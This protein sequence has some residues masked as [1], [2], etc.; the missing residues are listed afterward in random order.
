[1]GYVYLLFTFCQFR[2]IH[3]C[4]LQRIP[5]VVGYYLL[6]MSVNWRSEDILPDM[7]L[8]IKKTQT[9]VVPISLT[10][11]LKK[12]RTLGLIA[13]VTVDFTTVFAQD[14]Y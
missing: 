6:D 9:D 14:T 5:H 2:N 12:K 3:M 4:L 13:F 11:C 10:F 7:Y 1:M 8:F